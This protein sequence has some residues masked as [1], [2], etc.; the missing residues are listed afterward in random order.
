MCPA[1][2]AGGQ[3]TGARV[4]PRCPAAHSLAS[5]RPIDLP[6]GAERSAEPP[7]QGVWGWEETAARA[8]RSGAGAF[9]CAPQGGGSVRQGAVSLRARCRADGGRN[10]AW[11][12]S[13]SRGQSSGD[14][15]SAAALTG[16]R[17]AVPTGLPLVVVEER[18]QGGAPGLR[19]DR[20]TLRLAPEDAGRPEPATA[21]PARLFIARSVPRLLHTRAGGAEAR[22]GCQTASKSSLPQCGSECSTA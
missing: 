5:E 20:A 21:A 11:Q 17:A 6:T 14:A 18:V 13:G 7:D 2:M 8:E 10:G 22:D 12:P 9:R 3:G 15:V 4:R 16:P 1:A 19:R